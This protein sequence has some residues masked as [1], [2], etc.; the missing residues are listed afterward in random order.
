[1]IYDLLEAMEVALVGR[2]LVSDAGESVYWPLELVAEQWSEI[3]G[4]GLEVWEHRYLIQWETM[5]AE[6]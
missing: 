3:T 1:M 6:A 4:N 2:R 5:P